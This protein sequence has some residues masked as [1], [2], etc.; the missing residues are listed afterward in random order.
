M[1][2]LNAKLLKQAAEVLPTCRTLTEAEVALGGEWLST[3]QG[4]DKQEAAIVWGLYDGFVG[5][6]VPDKDT[7]IFGK[8]LDATY[9][10]AV[11]A[12]R[13]LSTSKLPA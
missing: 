3:E 9:R 13:R 12:G 5:R 2:T 10:Q 6:P 7:Y 4:R 8:S 11:E 1:I